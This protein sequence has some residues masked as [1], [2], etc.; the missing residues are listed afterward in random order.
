[1]TSTSR[2]A[3]L[4]ISGSYSE[5]DLASAMGV[6]CHVGTEIN[7]ILVVRRIQEI[8]LFLY[9]AYTL[10]ATDKKISYLEYDGNGGSVDVDIAFYVDGSTYS[11]FSPPAMRPRTSLAGLPPTVLRSPRTPWWWT[12]SGLRPLGRERRAP[13]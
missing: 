3:Q 10:D 9:G 2:L 5:N 1:M 4:L 7:D 8:K 12:T 11:P 13:Q 6:W